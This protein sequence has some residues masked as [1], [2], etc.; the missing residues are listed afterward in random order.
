MVVINKVDIG[1]P[2]PAPGA[3]LISVRTGEG[4]DALLAALEARVV[5]M[6][7]LREA[8]SLTR[9]RHRRAL[10][11]AAVHLKRACGGS[12]R[13]PELVAEDVR[14]AARALGRITGRVDV[15]DILD[16]VFGEFCIGK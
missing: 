9:S 5:A 8:P 2:S 11:D 16:V 10:E 7:G 6:M 15:E 13:E 4:I 3:F 12:D 14:L 1:R